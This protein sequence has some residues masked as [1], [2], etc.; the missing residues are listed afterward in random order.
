MK[1]P[2]IQLLSL[3]AIVLSANIAAAQA[4]PDSTIRRIDAIFTQ[5]NQPNSPGAV[6]G[7][8]RNDSLIFSRGYG[9]A[10]LEYGIPNTPETI[11]YMA[12][13][14][15]QF[16]AYSIL[17][18]LKQGKLGLDD[19]IR[20]YLP[21]FPDLHE[22]ITIR[23][24]LNHTSGI[25][26]ISQFGPIAGITQQDVLTEAQVVKI[27][28]RQRGLNFKPGTQFMYGNSDYVLL[29][30][31]VQAVSG[32]TFRQFTDSA[33]F[34]PLGMTSTHFHDDFAEIVANRAYSYDRVDN[35][36]FANSILN[37]AYYGSTGLLTNARDMAKW[38][39]NFYAPV[40]GDKS[41]I[42]RLAE[43]TRLANGAEIGYG[44]GVE[45][46]NWHNWTQLAHGGSHAGFLNYLR[47]IPEAKLGVFVF[48][49]RS[50]LSVGAPNDQVTSLFLPEAAASP[51]GN[52]VMRID[53][54]KAIIEEPA[55]IEPYLGDYLSEVGD[56]ARLAMANG[57]LLFKIGVSNQAV[58]LF[59]EDASLLVRAKHDTFV[60]MNSPST[61]LVFRIWPEGDTTI[62]M[63]SP[64]EEI[65][66]EKRRRGPTG[67]VALQKYVGSY[68]SA[69]ADCRYVIKLENHQ[70]ILTHSKYADSKL[71]LSGD[72]HVF[73]D[74][75]W[76]KHL[77][78][79]FDVNR[80]IIGFEVNYGWIRHLQFVKID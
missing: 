4:L 71:T 55:A 12:S 46:D 48:S 34:K 36:H 13:I 17:L 53:S 50:D 35:S 63:I 62:T 27:L 51:P 20:K 14:S 66:L 1:L 29:A 39:M 67:D 18:L 69:E 19:D 16:T 28:K 64:Y 75:W 43:K 68:Y 76:M 40:V 59:G 74:Y 11:W 45:I 26:D 72:R 15:K 73:T 56:H 70:L 3:P 61:K 49:N 30:E 60:V 10:N 78:M 8:V 37:F 23:Q 57:M 52:P 79:D 38:V 24:L 25:R 5:W 54:A 58:G 42:A 2:L 7:V 65:S 44:L 41:D 32:T 80:R 77:L 47:V 31:I 33:I 21:W 6:V 9:L 22:R